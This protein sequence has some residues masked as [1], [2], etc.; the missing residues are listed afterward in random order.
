MPPEFPSKMSAGDSAHPFDAA[1]SFILGLLILSFLLTY[2]DYF[3]HDQ[4]TIGQDE[5]SLLEVRF[6][7]LKPSL[8]PEGTFG[9]VTDK[10]DNQIYRVQYV[11]CPLVLV[12]G[13][14]S[15]VIVADFSAG[16]RVAAFCESNGLSVLRDFGNGTMLLTRSQPP[17]NACGPVAWNLLGRGDAFQG[18]LAWPPPPWLGGPCLGRFTSLEDAESPDRERSRRG[19]A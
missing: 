8:P 6:R 11:L 5:S 4:G 7:D 2:K 19:E 13:V 15:D 17:S 14:A 12:R 18:Q 16:K 3:W 1:M 10:D 9:F